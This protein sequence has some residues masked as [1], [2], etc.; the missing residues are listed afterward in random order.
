VVSDEL[1]KIF[2]SDSEGLLDL[3]SKP[4]KVSSN[5]RLEQSFTEINE[6]FRLRGRAP[7]SST[8]DL[9]ERKLGA[10]LEGILADEAKVNALKQIDEYN[11]LSLGSPASIDEIFEADALGLLDDPTGILDVSSLP[12][13]TTRNEPDEIAQRVKCAD[14]ENFAPLFAQKHE[15]L[16]SGSSKLVKFPGARYVKEGAFFV[17]SGVMVFVAEVREKQVVNGK[18]KER[19]RCV[20]ENGTESP[21]Y[22]LS[23]STRLYED[24]GYAVVPSEF[25]TILA[26]DEETGY[27]YVLSSL[28]DDPQVQSIHN[29]YKIGFSR[30][31]VEKRIA[32]AEKSP[33]YF[34]APVK[35]EA[36]YRTY[37]LKAQALEHLMHKVFSQVRLDV[38]QTNR[39]GREHA[40]SEWFV[41]PLETISHAAELVASGEIV[42][43]V[44]DTEIEKLVR[45]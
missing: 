29:L 45:I 1:R 13:R 44:Y 11:L 20:F 12:T 43:Y 27:L 6:F 26:D 7:E 31:P 10:R 38:V 24:D 14:F 17:S 25:E 22:R 36:T 23:L 37:N 8:S 21:M 4:I 41:V 16:R 19:L 33:T 2:E 3:P 18:A 9:A 28:S 30:G 39:D 42:H 40:P 15:E 35:I 34:M 32:G 5:D